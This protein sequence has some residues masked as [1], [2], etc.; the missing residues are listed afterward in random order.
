MLSII[1][2]DY[3]KAIYNPNLYFDNTYT[4]EWM[5]DDL[6]KMMVKDV[7]NSEVID[8]Y[9][10]KSPVLGGIPPERLSGGVKTLICI[11]MVP[12]KVFNA[13]TCGD[14]CAK[15]LLEM[16][17]TKEIT[18]NLRHLMDFGD[19]PFEIRIVNTDTVVNNMGE[20]VPVAGRLI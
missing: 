15:W 14:N 7:D 6:N 8:T 19:N 9:I 18:V 2:G 16:A 4:D 17:K 5:A 11:H 10:I 13:S 12:E 3:E 20:L 1:Y